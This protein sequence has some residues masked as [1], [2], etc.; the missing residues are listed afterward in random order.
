MSKHVPSEDMKAKISVINDYLNPGGE[1]DEAHFT[2]LFD[3]VCHLNKNDIVLFIPD[4]MGLPQSAQAK[5][6]LCGCG[7]TLHGDET[8][9]WRC[10]GK[11]P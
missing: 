4:D 10:G 6:W 9:C 5:D 11:G 1:P 7:A 2:A 8:S 3:V